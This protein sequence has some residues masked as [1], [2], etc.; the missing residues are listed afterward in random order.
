LE[1]LFR[2]SEITQDEAVALMNVTRRATSE[3]EAGKRSVSAEELA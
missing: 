3:V 1:L 2:K